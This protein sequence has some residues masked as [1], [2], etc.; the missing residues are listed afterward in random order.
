[1]KFFHAY[2]D[3]FNPGLEKNGFIN[4][5]T[6]FKLPHCFAVPLERQFNQFAVKDGP[7]YNF[8]KDGNFPFY[9]DRVAGGVIYYPYAFDKKNHS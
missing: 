9:V 5:D 3:L 4:K 7:L 1:M 8:I 6:G 2:S